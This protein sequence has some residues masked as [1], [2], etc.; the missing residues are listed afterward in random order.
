LWSIEPKAQLPVFQ[1]ADVNGMAFSSDGKFILTGDSEGVG[2]LWN[3][4][5]GQLLREFKGHTD[6]INYGVAFSPDGKKVV[7]S[8]WDKTV[9]I[10]D[11][12]TGEELY[13]FTDYTERV[14]SVAFSPDGKYILGR[15]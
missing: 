7:T 2:R 14:N 1:T 3:T 12:E 11:I 4:N 15:V 5:T 10:W 9:R 6:T 13:R 8:S